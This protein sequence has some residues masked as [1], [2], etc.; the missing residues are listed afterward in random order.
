MHNIKLIIFECTVHWHW[1]YS[2]CCVPVTTFYLQNFLIITRVGFYSLSCLPP[3]PPHCS[4]ASYLPPLKSFST[5]I[6]L[7]VLSELGKGLKE[8]DYGQLLLLDF[9]PHR[10]STWSSLHQAFRTCN[11]PL[12]GSWYFWHLVS[13]AEPEEFFILLQLRECAFSRIQCAF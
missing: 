7:L 13:G 10:I 12:Q 6:C 11:V 8:H 1:I 9:E 2:H 4:E 5:G 3:S